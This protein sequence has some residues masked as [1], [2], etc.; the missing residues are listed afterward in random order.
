[1][2][3]V[4][5][6]PVFTKVR[7]AWGKAMYLRLDAVQAVSAAQEGEDP[8]VPEARHPNEAYHVV[9]LAGG[10]RVLIAASDGALLSTLGV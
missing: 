5:E 3:S 9:T 8:G 4:T 6:L 2:R 7:D 1:M 10:S